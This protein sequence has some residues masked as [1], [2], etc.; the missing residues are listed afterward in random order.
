MG[1]VKRIVCLANSLK[2]PNGRC[3]A[4]IEVLGEK[5]Y[6]D[7]IR[8]VSTRPTA[9]VSFDNYKYRNGQSPT[10]LDILDI[11]L[12]NEAPRSHQTENHV[13]DTKRWWM[14]RGEFAWE[15]LDQLATHP[16]SIWINSDQTLSGIYD[17]MSAAE[18]GTLTNSLM[19]IKQEGLGV[20]VGSRT[21]EGRTKRVY[22]GRFEYNQTPYNLS[23]TDPIVRDRFSKPG[24]YE[25]SDVYLCL[26]LTEPYG[27]DGRCHKLVAAVITDPPL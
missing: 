15:D 25:L 23:V 2:P 16:D 19:L 18:A 22:R 6:G 4:G 9:D 1:Y 14:K 5:D 7:W 3:I 12:V 11:P 8:P 27:K 17:C 13:I 24:Y 20:E 21:W 10:L 26:S